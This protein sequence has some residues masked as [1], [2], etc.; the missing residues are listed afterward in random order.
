LK[1]VLDVA[2]SAAG[3]LLLSPFIGAIA[4]TIKLSDGG[5]VLYSGERIGRYG[6]PFRMHKFR[7]MVVN[8]D[9]LGGSSASGDDPRITSLGRFLRKSKL[10]E[11]P[12]LLNVLTGQM[13]LVGPRPE[14]SEYVAMYTEEERALLQLRPGITDWAS[15]WN[16]DEGATLAAYADPDAA[17]RDLIRPTKLRLQ[18]Q[19][20]TDHSLLTDL[21]I[22]SLTALAMVGLRRER[23]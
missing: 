3:L 2:S 18:L 14:V 13:S 8:A 17:Y 16:S 20:L 23:A 11:L 10:D 1:R 5:P 7:T 21:R 19:Y 6:V 22:L 12:Q 15:L 4:I 9:R